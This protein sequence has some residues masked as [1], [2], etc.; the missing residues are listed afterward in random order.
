[1]IGGT[2]ALDLSTVTGWAYGEPG[3]TP[4]PFSLQIAAGDKACQHISGTV[5]LGDGSK[6]NAVRCI[7]YTNFLKDLF[8][9]FEPTRVVYESPIIWGGKTAIDTAR[10]LMS[11]AVFTEVECN[12]AGIG[13]EH[14][15]EANLTDIRM[16][17]IGCAP[18]N[19]KSKP[20]VMARCD[21]LGWFYADNNE[22]DALA[23]LDRHL[24][25]MQTQGIL[26]VKNETIIDF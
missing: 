21:E 13:P 8:K 11:L 16:H 9:R 7:H 12:I 18:K 4:A 26:P 22:A 25:W 5:K 10:I 1:M 15:Y 24:F 23:L 3:S 2:L 14:C 19:K 20:L 17:F 6:D